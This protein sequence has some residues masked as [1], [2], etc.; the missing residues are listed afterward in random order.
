MYIKCTS[1][2]LHVYQ[3]VHLMHCMYIKCTSYAFNI[4]VDCQR[5]MSESNGLPMPPSTANDRK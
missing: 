5:L 2:A 1:Y 3:N 4:F